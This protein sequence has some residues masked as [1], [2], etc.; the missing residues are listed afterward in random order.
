MGGSSVFYRSG[1]A[2]TGQ[3]IS[4]GRCQHCCCDI[5]VWNKIRSLLVLSK[6]TIDRERRRAI[7][8]YRWSLWSGVLLL[9]LIVLADCGTNAGS[10]D[11]TGNPATSTGGPVRISSD[12]TRY[13]PTDVMQISVSN[14]LTKSI[15]AYDTRAS[16]SIFGLEMQVNGRWQGSSLARCPLGRM[17]RRVEIAAGK[18][19]SATIRA[20]GLSK[21]SFPPGT[22]RFSLSYS[23]SPTPS[24]SGVLTTIT[25][26]SLTVTAS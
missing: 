21:G 15:F 19:Y 7:Q 20:G 2:S 12:H 8:R 3:S 22:Y 14:Q 18:T 25:S 24:G 6:N 1:R 9:L 4:V 26:A 23:T 11:D 10:G 17:A 5:D 13:H 16:C